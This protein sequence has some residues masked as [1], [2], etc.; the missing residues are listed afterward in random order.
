MP[1]LNSVAAQRLEMLDLYAKQPFIPILLVSERRVDGETVPCCT[2]EETYSAAKQMIQA[3]RATGHNIPNSQCII[4]PAIGPIGA[5]TA[6]N[7]KRVLEAMRLIHDDPDFAG[8]HFSVGLSNF[9]VML[10]S[11]RADGSLVKGPLE[12][13]FL[14]KAMPLGLDTII[15]SVSRKYELLPPDHP[16]MRCLDDFLQM[17]PLEAILRVRDFYS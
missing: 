6:G 14:T 7:T 8:V 11:K 12:S 17:D 13:A 10:P 15:G 5:D 16:A 2:A 4:D 1:V 3:V 9:T